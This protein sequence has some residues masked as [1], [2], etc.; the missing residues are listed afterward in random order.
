[1]EAVPVPPSLPADLRLPRT[2]GGAAADVVA[3]A[4]AVVVEELTERSRRPPVYEQR[5]VSPLSLLPMKQLF[6]TISESLEGTRTQHGGMFLLLSKHQKIGR[7]L[8]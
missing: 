5:K 1:V 2:K 6:I 4:A 3:A 7:S 8:A